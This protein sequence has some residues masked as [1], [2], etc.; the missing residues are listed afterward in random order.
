MVSIPILWFINPMKTIDIS[1]I[2]HGCVSAC[3]NFCWAGVTGNSHV[4]RCDAA[5]SRATLALD[6]LGADLPAVL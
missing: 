3:V 2:S 1:W 6:S 5:A 4:S